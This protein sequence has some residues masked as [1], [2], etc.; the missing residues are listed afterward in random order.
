M[1]LK[2]IF[3]KDSV[4]MKFSTGWGFSCLVGKHILFDT[5]E[6]AEYLFNNLIGMDIDTADIKTVVISHH[7]WD[8]TNGLWEL[9]KK[10]SG[11]KVYACPNFS[12][13]FKDK[14][15]EFQ[16]KLIETEKF[17]KLSDNVFV[18]GEI[19]GNYKDSYIAE[20]AL[21]VENKDDIIVITGCS[22]PGILRIMEK[23]NEKF[24]KKRIKLVFGGFHLMD[25]DKREV[26]IIAEKLKNMGV[27][28]VG[29][30][31]CTGYDAQMIFKEYYG[32]KFISVKVG[33]IYNV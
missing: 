8:H 30:T 4:N 16:G 13:E 24:P 11:I 22:H 1:E 15:R 19:A 33:Q 3:D 2:I 5:G 6:K 28:K 32:R 7:H 21:V 14:V 26:N 20:Q 17:T 23:V 25:K 29:P 31:H 9:L 27:E 12:S 10:K 18:T